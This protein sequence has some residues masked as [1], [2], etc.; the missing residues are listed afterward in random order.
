MIEGGIIGENIDKT[1]D[2][3]D[4]NQNDYVQPSSVDGQLEVGLFNNLD[5]LGAMG[6]TNYENY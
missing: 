3:T 2:E 5:A 4:N 1:V 6:N